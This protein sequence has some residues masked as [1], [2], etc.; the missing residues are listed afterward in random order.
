[1]PVPAPPRASPPLHRPD[2]ARAL[3]RGQRGGPLRLG[4]RRVAGV[5]PG[6]AGDAQRGVALRCQRR[7][8]ADLERRSPR[9]LQVGRRAGEL[10]HQERGGP[11]AGALR[12]RHHAGTQRADAQRAGAVQRRAR[13]AHVDRGRAAGLDAERHGAVELRKGAVLDLQQAGA[14][15]GEPGFAGVVPARAGAVKAQHTV[16]GSAQPSLHLPGTLDA[17]TCGHAHHAAGEHTDAKALIRGPAGPVARDVELSRGAAALADAGGA[18]VQPGAVAE[19]HER[20]GARGDGQIAGHRPLRPRP[21]QLDHATRC[22][23]ARDRG[24]TA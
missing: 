8:A 10:A 3:H 23:G 22:R 11:A 16:A 12:E 4:E 5:Q 6:S 9:H 20:R 19:L 15:D 24:R 13:A 2:R 1:M 7:S 21:A 17:P 14:R 18:A